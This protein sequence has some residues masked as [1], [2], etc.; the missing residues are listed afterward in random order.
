M[1]CPVCGKLLTVHI[2]MSDGMEW[3]TRHFCENCGTYHRGTGDLK[4]G[5]CGLIYSVFLKEGLLGCEQCYDS[6]AAELDPLLE[7]YRGI[8]PGIVQEIAPPSRMARS[9]TAMINETI[10]DIGQLDEPVSEKPGERLLKRLPSGAEG[11]SRGAI[12]SCRVRLAR[13]IRGIPYYGRLSQ[14]NRRKLRS[15]LLAPG[16]GVVRLFEGEE[17][18][19]NP[20]SL[21]STGGDL[22][23]LKERN[24][25]SGKTDGVRFFPGRAMMLYTGDEDHIRCQWFARVET[26]EDLEADLKRILGEMRLLNGLYEWQF[27]PGYGYQTACPLNSGW[28][29]RISF[30]IGISGLTNARLWPEW[31]RELKNAG[32]E[33]RGQHGEGSP[34]GDEVQL[35]NRPWALEVHPER[36]IRVLL[37]VL[38]RIV[39]KEMERRPL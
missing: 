24:L 16:S 2:G 15:L 6:F 12:R 34:E 23:V 25:I 32:F 11:G 9:R 37:A 31:K 1:N 36:E 18:E 38:R 5:D 21:L 4:C 30:Q 33:I 7:Q 10:A 20:V 14:V 27:H 22:R 3:F 19:V 39:Q 13:N 28:G 17:G 35:S 26:L 29:V 8:A